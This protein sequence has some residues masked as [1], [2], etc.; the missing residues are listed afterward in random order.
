MSSIYSLSLIHKQKLAKD[1]FSFF[2]NRPKEFVYQPGQYIR[3][4]LPHEHADERGIS[5]FFTLSSSPHEEKYLTITVKIFDSTFKRALFS[6]EEG[7]LVQV[8]GPMGNFTLDKSNGDVVFLSGGIGITPFRSMI[9][10]AYA[11]GLRKNISLFASFSNREELLFYDELM[12]IARVNPLIKTIYSISGPNKPSLNI[13]S[14]RI[15]GK[16]LKKYI[17][18]AKIERYYLTGSTGMVDGMSKMLLSLKI[19]TSRIITEKF[20]GY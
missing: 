9:N 6:R 19:D 11:K 18:T 13:E 17:N 10:Y 7:C 2:F 14:G 1:T 12:S 5:R 16:L 4:I 15:N 3:L 20:S 8:F